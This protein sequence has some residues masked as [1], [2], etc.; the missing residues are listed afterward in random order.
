MRVEIVGTDGQKSKY[1]YINWGEALVALTA[2]QFHR[3]LLYDERFD[4][5]ALVGVLGFGLIVS[6]PGTEAAPETVDA[7]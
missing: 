6:E 3:A 5:E 4:G 2:K 1:R 7:P